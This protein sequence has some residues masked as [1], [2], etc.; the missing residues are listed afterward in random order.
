MVFIVK[1]LIILKNLYEL[2]F[3]EIRLCCNKYF[4]LVF[5][6]YKWGLG[7][8]YFLKFLV[9]YFYEKW[10]VEKNEL[11]GNESFF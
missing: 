11:I 10:F 1:I 4:Y 7:V 8:D 6:M 3:C 5:F 2:F 9:W